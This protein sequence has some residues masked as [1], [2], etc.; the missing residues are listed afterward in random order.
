MVERVLAI[1]L[2]RADVTMHYSGVRPL[3]RSD[4]GANAAISRDHSLAWH[5]HGTTPVLTLVGGKL[6]TWRA[7]GED[8]VS[9]VLAKLERIRIADTG[10]RP[11]P[12]NDPLPTGQ[13]ADDTLFQ[14]W[15]TETGSTLAEVAALWP[16]YGTRLR[17]I[18]AATRTAARTPIADGPWSRETIHWIIAHE[19]VARLADL[20][21]RRLLIIFRREITKPMLT[22]LARCFVDTGRLA[23][24]AVA[25]ELDHC[26]NRLAKYYGRSVI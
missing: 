11:I 26:M 19:S 24:S 1:P 7:F 15:A 13:P 4:G 14:Q 9:D 3:P 5:Q 8:V 21:E 22:D 18:L 25:Q 12:G 17:Q 2:T 20:V 23:E 16:L 10:N 6:T